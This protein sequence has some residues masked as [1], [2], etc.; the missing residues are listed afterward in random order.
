MNLTIRDAKIEDAGIILDFIKSIAKY[1]KLEDQVI[2]TIEDIKENIFNQK[3]AFV[4]IAFI[5]SQAVGYALY[6]YNYSTFKGKKGLYL[7]DLF[8]KEIYRQQGIGQKLHDYLRQKAKKEKCGRMEWT[9]L[10]WNQNARDF[11]EKNGAKPMDEWIIYR[12]DETEF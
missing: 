11:Y 8:V 2:V 9:C 12:L 10:D 3:Q 7:E 1:E 6:F 5:D 4:S